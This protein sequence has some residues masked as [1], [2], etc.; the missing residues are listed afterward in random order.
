LRAL[1]AAG[2][3]RPIENRRG[4]GY[5]LGPLDPTPDLAA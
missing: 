2:A 1:V 3:V 4:R 5:T